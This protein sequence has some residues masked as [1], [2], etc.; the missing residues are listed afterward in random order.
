MPASADLPSAVNSPG[1]AIVRVDGKVVP[2]YLARHGTIHGF[3]GCNYLDS[4]FFSQYHGCLDAHSTD[5]KV[6]GTRDLPNSL[7][8]HGNIASARKDNIT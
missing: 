2:R 4:L 6:L 5:T 3:K 1:A 8:Y 7:T